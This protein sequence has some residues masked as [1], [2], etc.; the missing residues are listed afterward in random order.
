MSYGPPIAIEELVRLLSAR[1]ESVVA[2]LYGVNVK[3][4]RVMLGDVSGNPG[5][6]LSIIMRH[7]VARGCK[8]GDWKDWS[9][10]QHG[11]ILNLI[12]FAKYGV[13]M[14]PSAVE[15]ARQF[16]GLDSGDTIKL[17]ADR[18]DME[19]KEKQA[20]AR[21][22][23]DDLK[24]LGAAKQ[25]FF[26]QAQADLIGTPVD[27][28]LF[29]RAIDIRELPSTGACRYAPEVLDY[30]TKTM[31][32]AMVLC[33]TGAD[34]KFSA[35]HRTY[36]ECEQGVWRVIKR[37]NPKG[38]LKSLK[39]SYGTVTGGHVSVSKGRAD[40]PLGRAPEGDAVLMAEGYETACCYA[41]ASPELRV[42]STVSLGNMASVVIPPTVTTRILVKENGLKAEGLIAFDKAVEAHQKQ[43]GDVR[44]IET[45]EGFSDDND[46]LMDKA[47][48]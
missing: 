37:P 36:L 27:D 26:Y 2:S 35:V 44:V 29:N 45:E 18:R 7:G 47:L 9:A 17:A 25:I 16:L 39:L 48:A 14:C 22:D 30:A 6:T 28:Y 46:Y 31:R 19:A 11:D 15:W 42:I 20:K 5:G 1:A 13:R 34:G 4:P 41:L 8:P 40:C 3:G 23:A 12:S 24:R 10:G 32:P 43:C 21:A 38:V 33:V